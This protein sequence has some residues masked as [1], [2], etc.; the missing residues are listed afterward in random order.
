[1][2]VEMREQ[3][4]AL[5]DWAR[6]IYV[7]LDDPVFHRTLFIRPDGPPTP[8][9]GFVTE[10][11]PAIT[12]PSLYDRV[13]GVEIAVQNF[14]RTAAELFHQVQPPADSLG[15]FTDAVGESVVSFQRLATLAA[16]DQHDSFSGLV[17]QTAAAGRAT[18]E[19]IVRSAG[20]L[21]EDFRFV[22]VNRPL[23]DIMSQLMLE[24]GCFGGF[25]AVISGATRQPARLTGPLMRA[26]VDLE[27]NWMRVAARTELQLAA[28]PWLVP[29]H[30][31]W[32]EGLTAFTAELQSLLGFAQYPEVARNYPLPVMGL[33]HRGVVKDGGVHHSLKN[34]AAAAQKVF[35]RLFDRVEEAFAGSWKLHGCGFQ[36]PR[37]RYTAGGV[38]LASLLLVSGALLFSAQPLSSWAEADNAKNLATFGG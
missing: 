26:W 38:G 29:D 5:N 25:Q 36:H 2:S 3:F 9:S 37:A 6:K 28:A 27:R 35:C 23:A 22:A 11:R 12:T 7:E 10:W 8:A 4:G 14:R 20:G 31:R 19:N 1:M 32:P 24:S 21:H 34:T 30:F 17:L 18:A 13:D 33:L 15:K 16:L